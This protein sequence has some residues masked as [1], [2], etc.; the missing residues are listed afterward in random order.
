MY[1]NAGGD[2]NKGDL[3]LEIFS[4]SAAHGA[5]ATSSKPQV[6]RSIPACTFFLLHRLGLWAGFPSFMQEGF[7]D[8]VSALTC[9]QNKQTR[10]GSILPITNGVMLITSAWTRDLRH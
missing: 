6:Q 3:A 1:T 9:L 5:R 10:T 4:N 2:T 7:S 8:V